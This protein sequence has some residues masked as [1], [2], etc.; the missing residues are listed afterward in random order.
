MKKVLAFMLALL[1]VLSLALSVLA[2]TSAECEACYEL[3]TAQ[4]VIYDDD[5]EAI[6]IYCE[7]ILSQEVLDALFYEEEEEEVCSVCGEVAGENAILT[8][9]GLVICDIC[10]TSEDEEYE[11]DEPGEYDPESEG[12]LGVVLIV[13]DWAKQETDEAHAR[14][15]IPLE[16]LGTDLKMDVTREQFAAIAV[17]LYE[18]ITGKVADASTENLPF[19][20]CSP[21]GTYSRYVAAAYKLGI[22]NGTSETTFTPSATITREQLATMLYRVI[23]KAREEGIIENELPLTLENVAFTDDAQISKYAHES[24]YYMA[25]RGIIKGMSETEFAPQGVATK[26]Q[27]ILISNRI[28]ANLY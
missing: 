14:N 3:I 5:G 28:A 15:L 27:A 12:S 10:S 6:C 1:L 11:S 18:R 26:E 19:T 13:S 17:A 8:D 24:V 20:D 22:T 16:M 9:D 7:E 4:D 2:E 25:K 21:T 23:L